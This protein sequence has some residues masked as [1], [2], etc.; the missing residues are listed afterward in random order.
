MSRRQ[1]RHTVLI[2]P[3]RALSCDE[4]LT[5]S[6]MVVKPI[7]SCILTRSLR[8]IS[9]KAPHRTELSRKS[10]S[11]IASWSETPAC[12]S[13]FSMASGGRGSAGRGATVPERG[14]AGK[15]D[16]AVGPPAALAPSP[17][18]KNSMTSSA[19]CSVAATMRLWKM[20]LSN[21]DSL[22]GRRSSYVPVADLH[23]RMSPP[24]EMLTMTSSDHTVVLVECPYV[25][26]LNS[27]SR[28]RSP[29]T[30]AVS[31]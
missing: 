4:R 13:G 10:Q 26:A 18:S 28:E 27:F 9:L 20:L 19:A 12:A 25:A 22:I 8:D 16:T 6:D 30:T 24:L 3:I 11:S 15:D 23:M 2:L 31:T 1:R 14:A 21:C 29:E 5:R 7:S 17:P